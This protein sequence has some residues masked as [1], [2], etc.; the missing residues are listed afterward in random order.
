M[1][2]QSLVSIIVPIYKV[3]EYLNECIES[4]VNQ[5][6]KN[7]ELIL[8]DDGSPDKCPQM[9]DDWARK[10]N[11]IRVIHKENGGLSSARNAGLDIIKGE[12]VAY[13]DSDDFITPN[14][15]EVMYDRI[16]NDATI[17]IVSGMIYHYK[18]GQTSHFHT[19]WKI[20]KENRV[21]S[22][23]FAIKCISEAVSFTVWNKLYRADLIRSIRFR[24]GRKNEDTLY[25]YDLGKAMES[26]QYSM[27]EIPSYVYYYRY[28]E[29]SICTS[30]KTPLYID[31]IKNQ[32]DMMDDCKD[33]NKRL[34]ETI[35]FQYS[36]KLF[37]FL[38]VLLLN[39]MWKPLYFKTYQKELRQIPFAY[40]RAKY[41]G[42]DIL[43]IQLLKWFPSMRKLII[44]IKKSVNG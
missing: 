8:V 5:T 7:I 17:G 39:D 18:D 25:I 42:K 10:D 29:D 26:T 36:K 6:Y 4:I 31:V 28:R 34:W 12:Y 41:K 1:N 30:K 11:R 27:V 24:E 35:Y 37:I 3:Q 15:V 20:E 23:N 16:K 44:M 32:H 33:S 21:D 40:I 2:K 38:D 9:C 14:Y 22:K 43:S 19:L 13:V